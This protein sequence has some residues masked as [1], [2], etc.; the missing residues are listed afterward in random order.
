LAP[1]GDYTI[2]ALALGILC[3]GSALAALVTTLAWLRVGAL[4]FL[5]AGLL[6]MG[7][8]LVEIVIVGFTALQ[9]PTQFPTWL[10]VIYLMVGAALALL[11]VRLWNVEA[12]SDRLR[13][14]P[15]AARSA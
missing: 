7:F 10:Q 8:E 2:P 6:M 15:D 12:G 4:A 5:L 14:R 1:F 9:S 13:H 3:G 11:G